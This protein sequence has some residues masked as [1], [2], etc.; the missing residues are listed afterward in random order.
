MAVCL[1]TTSRVTPLCVVWPTRPNFSSLSMLDLVG[2]TTL[3]AVCL[4]KPHSLV[5]SHLR[6][7]GNDSHNW[8]LNS[9]FVMQHTY[10]Y[11]TNEASSELCL[12]RTYVCMLVALV[13]Q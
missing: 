9:L 7:S 12:L 13:V 4:G 1:P 6:A 2:Q 8:I 11:N 10:V 3:C 5:I